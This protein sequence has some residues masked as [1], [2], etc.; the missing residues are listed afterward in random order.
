M[1]GQ[2]MTA[3]ALLQDNPA[4]SEEEIATAMG[5]NYCRCGCYVRIRRAVALAAEMSAIAE[6]E[7][8]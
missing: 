2:I 8:A 5:N 4:P 7:T 3:A 1:S 6:E